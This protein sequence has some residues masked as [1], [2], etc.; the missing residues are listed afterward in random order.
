M[1][2]PVLPASWETCMR[3]KKQ[4]LECNMEQLTGSK[5]GKEYDKTV[6]CYPVYLTY[7]QSTSCKI[8]G[9]MSYELESSFLGEIPTTWYADVTTLKAESK[10]KLM[11]LLMKT[12]ERDWKS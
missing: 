2:M 1:E 10:E 8:L 5:L 9:W 12:K 3:V 7:V 4:Q 6:Y 11:S